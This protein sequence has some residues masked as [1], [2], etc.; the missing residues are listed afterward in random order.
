MEGLKN[1]LF[2]I[3]IMGL[4]ILG[5]LLYKETNKYELNGEIAMVYNEHWAMVR[6]EDG[7]EREFD[8]YGYT[9]GQKV[10]VTLDSMDTKLKEDDEIIKIYWCGGSSTK[11]AK[12]I[13][14]LK[15]IDKVKFIWYNKSEYHLI[16]LLKRDRLLPI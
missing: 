12:E 7:I 5:L 4:F 6:T 2:T 9:E 11:T 10:V 1:I 16:Y 15:G 8:G 3:A 14:F 13:Y